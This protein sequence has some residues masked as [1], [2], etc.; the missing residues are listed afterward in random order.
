MLEKRA[1]GKPLVRSSYAPFE[2]YAPRPVPSRL[3]SPPIGLSTRH[4]SSALLL[5]S[6]PSPAS[7]R[8]HHN[9]LSRRAAQDLGV[10]QLLTRVVVHNFPPKLQLSLQ[11]EANGQQA[12]GMP[13]KF[14]SRAQ[15]TLAIPRSPPTTILGPPHRTR[16]SY[17][18]ISVLARA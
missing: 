17:P 12:H 8:S 16:R 3:Y 7:T 13:Q 9:P 4:F 5:R 2:R 14:S 15:A 10:T 1:L 18:A 6:A 11:I